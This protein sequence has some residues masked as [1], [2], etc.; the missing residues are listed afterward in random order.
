MSIDSGGGGEE[1][2]VHCGGIG[3]GGMAAGAGGGG[4][5]CR[6]GGITED[7]S[8]RYTGGGVAGVALQV[9]QQVQLQL[10]VCSVLGPEEVAEA[11]CARA[12]SRLG[13]PTVLDVLPV[14]VP[15]LLLEF[16]RLAA[17]AASSAA[18]LARPF[19]FNRISNGVQR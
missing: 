18:R 9:G 3:A 5:K 2:P 16:V 13:L 19:C 14:L 1:H 7:R 11:I 4:C 17:A 15:W 8:W 6:R 10:E 12:C